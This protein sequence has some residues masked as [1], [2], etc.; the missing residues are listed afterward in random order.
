MRSF[1]H[2]RFVPGRGGS[3]QRESEAG[4]EKVLPFLS[5]KNQAV[6]C[7]EEQ[8]EFRERAGLPLSPSANKAGCCQKYPL[9][10]YKMDL[11][12]QKNMIFTLFG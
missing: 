1:F 2:W 3:C 11:F 9:R 5:E 4:P 10:L 7:S 8:D 6:N 12:Y